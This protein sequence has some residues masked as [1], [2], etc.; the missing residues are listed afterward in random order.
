M[1]SKS[2]I[3][4][5][6]LGGKIGVRLLRELETQ[7]DLSIA[8][9]PSVAEVCK[10]IEDDP[11]LAYRYT[12][13]GNM[14]AVATDGTAVLGLGNI[15]ASASIPVMEGK[16]VLFKRFG[17]VDAWPICVNYRVDGKTDVEKFIDH[18]AAETYYGGINLEDIAAPACFDHATPID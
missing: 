4:E 12:S 9:T 8:Y 1:I 15:G 10:I 11:S 17:E 3:L 6:H 5:M 14:V 2:E 13:K 16:A 7:K 18:I